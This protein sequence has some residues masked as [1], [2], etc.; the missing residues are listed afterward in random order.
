MTDRASW[1]TA[2]FISAGIYV[3]LSFLVPPHQTLLV[4][5]VPGYEEDT[6]FN[7]GRAENILADAD[8]K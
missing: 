7:S 6:D 4:E 8:M 2:T 1:L 3:A 5:D